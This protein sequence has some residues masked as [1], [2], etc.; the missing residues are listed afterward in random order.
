MVSSWKLALNETARWEW[1][2][3]I[4][5]RKLNVNI[6]PRGDSAAD[7]R[8][9]AWLWGLSSEQIVLEHFLRS[10]TSL[11][12]T[13]ACFCHLFHSAWGL[14]GDWAIFED[15]EFKNLEAPYH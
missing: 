1:Q 7:Q 3:R 6:G 14:E 5:L 10:N 8:N 2:G 12:A 11:L 4:V 9:P 13:S 15:S